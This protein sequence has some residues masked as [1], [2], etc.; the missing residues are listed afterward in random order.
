MLDIAGL[1]VDSGHDVALFGMSHPANPALPYQRY[2]PDTVEL[3]PPPTGV[4]NKARAVGRMFWSSSAQRGIRSVIEE[5]K[6]D[7]IHCHNIYH[8]LSPSILRSAAAAGVPVVM[9]LHDYKLACP[10][11]Q[12]LDN[13]RVC[14]ACL[15]RHFSQAAIRGCR[16]NSRAQSGLMA[17]EVAVHTWTKAYGSIACFLC[18]SQFLADTMRRA[19]VYPDRLKVLPNFC[20][21]AEI[22]AKDAPGGPVVFAG[23]L[24]PEKGVDTLIEAMKDVP[25]VECIIAGEGPEEARLRAAAG[26]AKSPVR[27]VG[28]LGRDDTLALLRSASC[29][30]VP[31]RWN[32]NQPIV[33]LESFACAVP[34]VCTTLGG[35]PDLVQEDQ[36]GLMVPPNSPAALAVAINRLT[37]DPVAAYAMG[38]RARRY[39][40]DHHN[41]ADHIE[42]LT[43]VYRQVAA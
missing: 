36:T 13:G 34:V 29:T 11:Y 40:E 43:S 30:A 28:R 15:P 8:H 2:F 25:G 10:T 23:R 26:R 9:T 41:P 39:V 24:S 4:S 37:S 22:A 16:N 12:M 6:P 14:D 27:F 20:A 35:L 38:R 31:S 7:V 18:P 3:E 21:S 33:I 5:F 1:L 32:E 19:K 17:L 42:A